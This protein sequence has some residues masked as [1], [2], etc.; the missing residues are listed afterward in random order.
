MTKAIIISLIVTY[1]K[2]FGVDP[3]VAVAV[4]EKE[5]M[6]KVDAVGEA[7]EIGIMQLMPSTY[8]MFTRKQL[9][10]PHTNI[11]LGLMRLKEYQKNCKHKNDI[12]YLVCWN[13]GPMNANNV[14]Y[15]SL[16]PYVKDVKKRMNKYKRTGLLASSKL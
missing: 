13:Y 3:Y 2:F 16:F 15:P 7:G 11:M 14:K 9:Q 10:E 12:D 5:S 8:P 1:S 4:A 6:F